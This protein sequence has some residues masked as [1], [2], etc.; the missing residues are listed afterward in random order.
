[1]SIIQ[2]IFAYNTGAPISGTTQVGDIAIIENEAN[3]YP[4]LGG[5][6]WWGGP[7]ESQ[8]YVIAAPVSGNTQP[9][10]LF[11][12]NLILS[13]TYKGGDINL[14]NSNQTALQQFGYQ[15]SVL[16]QTLI[17][18][19]D[20]VMFSV[21]SNVCPGAGNPFFQSIG[22]G[23]TSMNYSTQY[24]AYP[25]ND[26]QSVGFSM[27]GNFYFNGS[28]VQ[29]AL[30]TWT[31]TDII[32]VAVDLYNDLIWIR[33]NGGAW[34]GNPAG[35]NDPAT[36]QGGLSLNGLTFFYP[37]LSPGNDVGQMTIQNSA[38]YGL[39]EGYQLLG[40]NVT[41][42]VKF[43]GTKNMTNPFNESTFVELTNI[44]FNQS[45]SNG[46]DASTWLTS[47]GYWNSWVSITP[48][49]T[50]T[51][52]VTPTVTPTNTTTSTPT[53][54]V[55]N[56]Q[57]PTPS[58]TTTSTPTL[59][60][61]PTPTITPTNTITPTITPSSTPAPGQIIVAAG[62]VNALS[63]SYDGD[64]WVN[65]S[66]GATFVSQPA[67]AVASSPTT[68]VAGGPNGSTARL[69]YS[70]N[71]ITWSAST[72]GNTLFNS[73]NGIA[74]GG[75]KFVAVGINTSALAGIAYSTDGITWT[76]SNSVTGIFGSVPLSVAYNGSR[77]VA[78]AQPGG[79][80]NPKNTIA[81]SDDGI[82]WT[83]SANSTSIFT[84]S[85][86][87]VA[88]GGDKWVAV[89]TG[90]N[91]MAYSTDGIT[92]SATTNGNTII[93]GTG[94]GVRYN[95]SQ[96]V[97]V[98][99]GTNSIAYSNNGLTWSASTNGNTIFSFQGYCITWDSFDSQWIAG[100]QGT[101]QLAIS[102]DGITWSAT[103]NGN[104]I[105]NDRVLALSTRN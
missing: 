63:Y 31:T 37:V 56:T 35:A 23:T 83:A 55:T 95:G 99:Q 70:N 30:P 7:D 40:V 15:Q 18:N 80:A 17:N 9:T 47:N 11:S 20:K 41:A 28:I 69:I 50:S 8:G 54:S 19:V 16:G 33:V 25:G 10:P 78:T 52:S 13:P 82:T 71:G 104:T 6:T 103:T 72:N 67:P 61:T 4:G 58:V 65:S 48:T 62:G 51:L 94:Y 75:G 66:N 100:G 1:M 45:F 91:R 73:V 29:S 101:N 27:D 42:S 86:R 12:G 68:F 32:D 44:S 102:T 3:Y 96:W 26:T 92:W 98:G 87:G 60:P 38:I 81:Y 5:L 93:T 59:T 64:N 49:P 22:V 97:A 89:G 76:A 53:P 105:M 84:S 85:G 24:G 77:W 46:N 88:W 74:Y 57:T 90:T 39:P 43:L 79:G 34:A 2:Q 36:N 21:Q 14:S